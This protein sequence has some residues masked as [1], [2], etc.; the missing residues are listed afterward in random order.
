MP[1]LFRQKI[2]KPLPNLRG[3][4]YSP[5]EEIDA[6]EQFCSDVP[7]YTAKIMQLSE[8]QGP[9]MFQLRNTL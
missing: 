6:R 5:K 2:N 9:S 8:E 4:F 3:V 7:L 1:Y